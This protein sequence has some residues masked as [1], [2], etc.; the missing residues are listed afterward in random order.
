[1]KWNTAI[2]RVGTTGVA[3]SSP[4]KVIF[5]TVHIADV[6]RRSHALSTDSKVLGDIPG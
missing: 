3:L 5:P 6:N 1:M 4:D 2:N